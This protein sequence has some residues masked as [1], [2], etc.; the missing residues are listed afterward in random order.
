MYGVLSLSP[1][2]PSLPLSLPLSPSFSFPLD[3]IHNT[4]TI[5]SI[6]YT[7]LYSIHIYEYYI[8]TIY[9][10]SIHIYYETYIFIVYLYS[11]GHTDSHGASVDRALRQ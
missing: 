6:L 2:L 10:Y 8:H 3:H 4:N 9:E 7:M 5:Y 1:S 11:P